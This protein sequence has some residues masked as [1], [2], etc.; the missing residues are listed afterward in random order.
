MAL[1]DWMT[2]KTADPNQAEGGKAAEGAPQK[3]AEELL[4]ESVSNAVR[5]AVGPLNE[6][7]SSLQ[8]KL[9]EAGKPKEAAQTQPN[10]PTSFF[11]DEDKAF[12]ERLE[13]SLQLQ[14][15]T[16]AEL[17]KD[18]VKAEY[19]E[20]WTQFADEIDQTLKGSPIQLRADP[21]YIRNVADMVIGRKA[22]E[23][24]F[25]FD[26]ANKKFFIED[27]SGDNGKNAP[28]TDDSG[29]TEKQRRVFE[30]MGV[31]IERA[32]EVVKSLEFVN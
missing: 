10:Q 2:R 19:G 29:L 15:D 7:I 4:A 31:P 16:R 1:P 28:A 25:R 24:G 14:L 20:I 27:A 8:Q 13:P 5:A 18:R 22:R 32:K 11:D 30:R 9:E 17:M 6:R 23:N 3:S 21:V 26:A 12:R